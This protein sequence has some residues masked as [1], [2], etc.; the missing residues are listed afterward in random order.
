MSLTLTF[1]GT[2][3]AIPTLDRNVASLAVQREGETLLFDCGEGT[4]RQM[5][6]SVGL[7]NLDAIFI[8]HLHADHYLGLPGLIKSYEMQDREERLTIYGPP[9]LRSLF[10]SLGRVIGK[11]RYGLELVEKPEAGAYDLIILAVAHREFL[12]LGADGI[13]AFGKPR[14]AQI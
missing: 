4:Q 9:G 7:I 11:P 12:A 13:R 3:A 1:L 10:A 5:Q 6:R 8:T 2:G 14:A